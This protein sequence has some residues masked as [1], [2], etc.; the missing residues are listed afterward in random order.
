MNNNFKRRMHQVS[1]E[2]KLENFLNT[3]LYYVKSNNFIFNRYAFFVL[4]II[5]TV[6]IIQL[7]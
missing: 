3:F 1:Q 6:L 2:I 5:C 7:Y 4:D